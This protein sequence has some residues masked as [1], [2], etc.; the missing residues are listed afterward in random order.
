M[1]AREERRYCFQDTFCPLGRLPA[2][3]R[4]RSQA[5]QQTP[6]CLQR[7]PSA[8]LPEPPGKAPF[9]RPRRRPRQQEAPRERPEAPGCPAVPRRREAGLQKGSQPAG[10]SRSARQRFPESP[11]RDAPALSPPRNTAMRPSAPCAV[12]PV[13]QGTERRQRRVRGGRTSARRSYTRP[14]RHPLWEKR[15]TAFRC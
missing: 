9:A 2:P 10:Q 8:S 1:Q 4:R 5:R 7:R 11:R 13:P 12:R 3:R 15:K 6:R 14:S